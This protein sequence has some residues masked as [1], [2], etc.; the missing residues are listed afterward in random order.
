MKNMKDVASDGGKALTLYRRSIN[1]IMGLLSYIRNMACKGLEN[2]E[3]LKRVFNMVS[4]AIA[5]H[6]FSCSL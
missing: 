4:I 5:S 1:L 2:H 3:T 6:I